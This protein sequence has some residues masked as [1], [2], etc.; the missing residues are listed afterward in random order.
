M[1]V[2]T[3]E[4]RWP[5]GAT[6]TSRACESG[7]GLRGR[8]DGAVGAENRA[9]QKHFSMTGTNDR[10]GTCDDL[11][12][13]RVSVVRWRSRSGTANP[14]DCC[15][16]DVQNGNDVVKPVSQQQEQLEVPGVRFSRYSAPKF[17]A[18]VG[19]PNTVLPHSQRFQRFQRF[20]L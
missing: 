20:H 15:N 3:S 8:R 18:F 12:L 6:W 2:I 14:A 4:E 19:H 7:R 1:R 11:L 17:D 13:Y 9:V 10:N 16:D 5:V